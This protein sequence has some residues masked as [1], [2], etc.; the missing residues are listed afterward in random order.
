MATATRARRGSKAAEPVEEEVVE[1]NGS[2][3]EPSELHELMAEYFNEKYDAGVTPL[4]CAI[5]TSKRT[6]F[7][8]S[9]AYLEYREAAAEGAEERA[10]EAVK[11]RRAKA[12]ADAEEE[13]EAEEAKPARGR[14][15]RKPA[16]TAEAA[17]AEKAAP[18]R[19]TRRTGKAEAEAPA[20]EAKPAATTRRRRSAKPAAAASEEEPF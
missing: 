8:K 18:A 5:F 6:E 7:R 19:R 2:V 15:A 11:T 17:P 14:R 13:P 4:Q 1:P 12:K 3:R 10:A 9:D 20:E 16:A